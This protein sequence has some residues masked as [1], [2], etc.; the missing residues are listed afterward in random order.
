MHIGDLSQEE[1][2]QI[3]PRQMQIYQLVLQLSR[4]RNG[5]SGNQ[6]KQQNSI[7]TANNRIHQQQFPQPQFAPAPAGLWFIFSL[8]YMTDHTF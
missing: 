1:V 5:L 7:N 3:R 8:E 4:C 6:T 2:K